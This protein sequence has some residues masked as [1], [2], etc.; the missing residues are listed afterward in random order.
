MGFAIA[1]DIPALGE[2]LVCP[3]RMACTPAFAMRS[4]VWKSG[5][6]TDKLIIS[7]IPFRF[8]SLAKS[9]MPTVMLGF[10]RWHRVLNSD[11]DSFTPSP[12]DEADMATPRDGA[13]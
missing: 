9:V 10:N 13:K 1:Q 5:S 4:G 12:E 6:P 3:L 11:S 7:S 8:S 2:Y